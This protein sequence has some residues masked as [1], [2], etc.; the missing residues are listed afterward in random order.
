MPADP[1]YR[2]GG[3]QRGCFAIAMGDFDPGGD[4]GPIQVKAQVLRGLQGFRDPGASAMSMIMPEDSPFE[5]GAGEPPE[6]FGDLLTWE[7]VSLG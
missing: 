4:K 1:T 6:Q 7:I 5:A 2:K 3:E